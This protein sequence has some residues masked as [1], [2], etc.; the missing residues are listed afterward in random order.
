M[1]RKKT[2]PAGKPARPVAGKGRAGKPAAKSPPKAERPP[3]AAPS[4]DV[5]EAVAAPPGKKGGGKALPRKRSPQ[6]AREML[7]VELRRV[8]SLFVEIGERYLADTEGRIVS[9]IEEIDRRKLPMPCVDRLLK[10]VRALSVKARK[11]R[12]KDL[13]RI[14]SLVEAFRKTLED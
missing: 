10:D 11:G 14:E 2:P 1:T 7:T 9:V 8:R 3:E 12:R 5:A 6:I 13:G 4:P